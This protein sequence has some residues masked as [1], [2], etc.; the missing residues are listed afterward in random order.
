MRW[1]GTAKGW[2]SR[3]ATLWE[4]FAQL[5]DALSCTM[6]LHAMPNPI[7]TIRRLPGFVFSILIL[8]DDAEHGGGRKSSEKLSLEH[9]KFFVINHNWMETCSSPPC[10]G[11][12]ELWGCQMR[13]SLRIHQGRNFHDFHLFGIYELLIVCGNPNHHDSACPSTK[14]TFM[15]QKINSQTSTQ[16]CYEVENFI[17]SGGEGGGGGK[18][19]S[20]LLASLRLI[21]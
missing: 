7:N 13:S 1:G 20:S 17:G 9:Y 2:G 16:F 4:S 14:K 6:R 5:N 15:Q 18:T 19:L 10:W 11:G 12:K 3:E 8:D 21:G